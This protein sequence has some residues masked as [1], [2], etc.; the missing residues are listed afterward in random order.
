MDKVAVM[1]QE[2]VHHQAKIRGHDMNS[3]S[4]SISHFNGELSCI[5]TGIVDQ[6][7]AEMH[8]FAIHLCFSIECFISSILFRLH[9]TYIYKRLI[10]HHECFY[11]E[12]SDVILFFFA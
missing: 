7:K 5:F 12:H 2:A 4:V 11:Q 8:F 10:N 6:G 9:I 1:I 3:S